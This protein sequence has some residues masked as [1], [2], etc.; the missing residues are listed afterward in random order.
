MK[1]M[2]HVQM[3][4]SIFTDRNGLVYLKTIFLLGSAAFRAFH[5]PHFQREAG[6]RSCDHRAFKCTV[7]DYKE[8][9]REYS[10]CVAGKDILYIVG[11]GE[12]SV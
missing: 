11:R 4:L 6:W 10:K 2:I 5:D 12:A 8:V 9:S 7:Q 3:V 1:P